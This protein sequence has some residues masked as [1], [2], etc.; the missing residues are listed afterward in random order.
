M[1]SGFLRLAVEG[2]ILDI[3]FFFG[4]SIRYHGSYLMPAWVD[5]L[6]TGGSAGYLTE[7]SFC[8]KLL[9]VA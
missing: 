9:I 1:K 2:T 5:Q 3:L 6:E 4:L 8:E 7:P